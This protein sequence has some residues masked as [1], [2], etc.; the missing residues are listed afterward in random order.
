MVMTSLQFSHLRTSVDVENDNFSFLTVRM[1]EAGLDRTKF[2]DPIPLKVKGST[3]II[4]DY[5]EKQEEKLRHAG[6][7]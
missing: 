6:L 5:K 7:N 2:H 3:Y 1:L 4:L